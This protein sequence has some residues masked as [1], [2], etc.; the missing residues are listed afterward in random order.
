MDKLTIIG[1]TADG[2]M[3]RTAAEY[4]GR[5]KLVLGSPRLLKL[6][7]A[8]AARLA[9][10]NLIGKAR[11]EAITWGKNGDETLG[12]LARRKSAVILASGDPMCYGLGSALA[13]RLAAGRLRVLPSPSAF[14][15]AAARLGWGLEEVVTLSL[16]GTAA[17]RRLAVLGRH[18]APQRKILALTD[19]VT[20]P[21][22]IADFL[23]RRGYGDSGFYLLEELGGNNERLTAYETAAG[24]KSLRTAALNLVGI[25]CRRRGFDPLAQAVGIAAAE[26]AS[27]KGQISKPIART[28]A[29]AALAPS[30]RQLLWDIGAG[31]GSIAIEWLRAADCRAIAIEANP[32]RA[33]QIRN[34]A[35]KMGVPQL[36]IIRAAAPKALVGLPRPDAV[37]VGGGDKG[38][39]LFA[40]LRRVLQN[41]GRL[42]ATAVTLNGQAALV[43]QYQ[44]HGGELARLQ[45]DRIETDLGKNAAWRNGLAILQYRWL[46]K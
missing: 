21:K 31:S 8:T 9:S 46:K 23:V 35:E 29:L 5:A 34:N 3:S 40:L 4:L 33:G 20:T 13:P 37:F 10:A 26:Y 18:L 41:G 11:V 15:L 19:N 43:E 6:V 16:H 44:K 24:V 25:D 28:A 32:K 12:Q 14:S 7:A 17:E 38:G 2:E 1:V 27:D 42:V 36:R 39:E 30:Y 22:R 45:V